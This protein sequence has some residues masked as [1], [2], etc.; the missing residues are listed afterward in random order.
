MNQFSTMTFQQKL[1]VI[2]MGIIGILLVMFVFSCCSAI[3]DMT[4]PIDY[5]SDLYVDGADVSHIANLF[6]S[7]ANG[8]IGFITMI[9]Y[10]IGTFLW[11][12]LL[13]VPWRLIAIRKNSVIAEVEVK[14]SKWVLLGILILSFLLGFIGT[15][16]TNGL[17]VLILT[18]IVG[19][20][21]GLIVLATVILKLRG[22][23]TFCK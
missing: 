10:V 13:L 6:I 22:N 5:T 21:F 23:I 3:G 16:F 17:L 4:Q 20:M 15:K 9:G 12:L 11:S 19:G 7:G 18:G 1:R 14:L 8:F 2:S